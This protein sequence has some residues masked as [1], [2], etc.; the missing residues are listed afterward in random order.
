MT[1]GTGQRPG[2]APPY[3]SYALVRVAH[4]LEQQMDR[5]LAELDLSATGFGVL[6]QLQHAP[7][8]SSAELA[9]RVIVT[10]QSIGPLLARLERDGLVGRHPVG[11]A[12]TAIITRI[13][14][15]GRQRL[16]EAA[17][18][19]QALE[20]DLV[21]ALDPGARDDLDVQ[22]WSMLASLNT[23]SHRRRREA[24]DA[25]AQQPPAVGYPPESGPPARRE[26]RS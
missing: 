26:E 25:M 2:G 16:A 13:T 20:D 21:E 9:R 8:V 4:L 6:F 10:P 12:G 5:L 17:E 15:T 19:V 1:S 11:V 24:P 23:R 7:E 3:V 18:R 22:L 14:D